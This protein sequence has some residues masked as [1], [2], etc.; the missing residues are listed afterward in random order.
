MFTASESERDQIKAYD[1]LVNAD[2]VKPMYFEN[3]SEAIRSTHS[4]S[5]PGFRRIRP[6]GEGI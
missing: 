2:I 1:L 4:G 6:V 3:L 5:W